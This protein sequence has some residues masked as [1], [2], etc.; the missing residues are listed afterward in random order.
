MPIISAPLEEPAH[1]RPGD[2]RTHFCQRSLPL[3]AVAM[4]HHSTQR[5]RNARRAAALL[6]TILAVATWAAV[7]RAGEAPP[8][9]DAE[10]KAQADDAAP[11]PDAKKQP[12][13]PPPPFARLF[14]VGALDEAQRER[15]VAQLTDHVTFALNY[16]P[17]PAAPTKLGRD[18][19][20]ASARR[21]E[22]TLHDER[23]IIEL[24]IKPAPDKAAHL[25]AFAAVEADGVQQPSPD[26]HALFDAVEGAV[27]AATAAA[28]PPTP[29]PAKDIAYEFIAL[30]YV[31]TDRALGLLKALGYPV[32]EYE[33]TKGESLL[34]GIYKP[35]ATEE[36]TLPLIVKIA[37]APKTTLVTKDAV[38]SGLSAVNLPST[39]GQ[40][41]D[42]V[43]NA[44]PQQR[45]LI[46][47]DRNQPDALRKLLDLLKNTVDV[48]ARQILIEA[49]VLEVRTDRLKDLGVEFETLRR[50][51]DNVL[52]ADF[53]RRTTTRL[54]KATFEDALADLPTSQ[55]RAALNI[56]MRE[57]AAEILSKPSVVALNNRQARIQVGQ[58]IPISK[59]VSTQVSEIISVDYFHVGIVL[60]IKPR[61]SGD[62]K[63]VSMQ[64]ETIVSDVSSTT[65][66]STTSTVEVAPV[67]DTRHVQTYARITNGTPF[68]IGGL[69]AQDKTEVVDRIPF[70]S[71]LPF[72]GRLFQRRT[73]S[74][75]K[76]EV[77]VVLTPHIIPP[78]IR[79]FSTLMPKDSEQFD[80]VGNALFRNAYR[81]RSTDI[82]DLRFLSESAPV[83]ATR[84]QVARAIAAKPELADDPQLAAF[85]E[86]Y[87]PGEEVFVRRMLYEIAGRLN[88]DRHIPTE[89]ILYFASASTER[90]TLSVERLAPM[91]LST[92]GTTRKQRRARS[93][94]TLILAFPRTAPDGANGPSLHNAPIVSAAKV[95]DPD[96]YDALL[97]DHNEATGDPA[98]L[99]KQGKGGPT[100]LLRD[101]DDL[102]RLKLCLLLKEAVALNGSY[103]KLTLADFHVGRQIVLPNPEDNPNKQYVIDR[104]VARYFYQSRMYY[105]AFDAEFASR[106]DA[107]KKLLPQQ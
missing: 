59:T 105:R 85:A 63:E 39:S 16:E 19:A 53:G 68:I 102:R 6:A 34:D 62:D 35:I 7:A 50:R 29:A 107:L 18:K 10:P 64:V 23:L 30:S 66:A 98:T 58:E 99:R 71:K 60:N 33:I 91:W 37:D 89:N 69:I 67:V 70:I 75:A 94:A 55:F 11:K 36:T 3:G 46:I 83:A 20:V 104:E 57:G 26:A 90:G 21:F 103:M 84:K 93:D 27:A 78:K 12:P 13:P 42:H 32:V 72:V 15:L 22:R 61:I 65:S 5:R 2:S 24:G 8:K 73:T 100:I 86:G 52:Q 41:M 79:N 43:T 44:G 4:T 82:Y 88:F 92:K 31:Q 106:L 1:R 28:T 96:A 80:S 47:H 81:L 48:A 40:V 14:A 77:V 9:P 51:D 87:L 56:L 74:S 76:T 97:I 45:L 38:A 49:L 17:A 95:A 54:Y 101:D 25:I